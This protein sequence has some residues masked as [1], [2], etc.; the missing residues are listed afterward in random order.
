MPVGL[1]SPKRD[2]VRWK[3]ARLVQNPAQGVIL[4]AARTHTHDGAVDKEQVDAGHVSSQGVSLDSNKAVASLQ[5]IFWKGRAFSLSISPDQTG[6]LNQT[7]ECILSLMDGI[8]DVTSQFEKTCACI[9]NDR[10][11]PRC[12]R[13]LYHGM[14][15]MPELAVYGH[16]LPAISTKEKAW[17]KLPTETIL[18]SEKNRTIDVIIAFNESWR[19][20][21]YFSLMILQGILP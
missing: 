4:P 13:S 1:C 11:K 18:V 5:P 19:L 6:S 9:G 17:F 3:R 12:V 8:H 16:F 15:S 2:Q 14:N 7:G 10:G 20:G 21:R